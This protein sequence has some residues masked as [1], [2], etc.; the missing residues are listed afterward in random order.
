MSYGYDTNMEK[1]DIDFGYT[2]VRRNRS[3]KCIFNKGKGTMDW[4]GEMIQLLFPRNPDKIRVDPAIAM[5]FDHIPERLY[6]F[7]R[8]DAKYHSL[9]NFDYDQVWLL[10]PEKLNDPF[11]CVLT[12]SNES[13]LQYQMCSHLDNTIKKIEPDFRI[14]N[15]EREFLKK[16]DDILRDLVKIVVKQD[17][18][19]REENVDGFATA[20]RK[21][22]TEM[23]QPLVDGVKHSSLLSS[24]TER[25]DSI[26]MWSHYAQ[27]HTG[28]CL[29]YDLKSLGIDSM[30]TRMLYPILYRKDLLD[31]TDFIRR[32]LDNEKRF[33]N[34][35]GLY[36]AI[37]K[38]IEWS[39]EK[40][41]RLVFPFGVLE[42]EQAWRVPVPKAVYLGAKID[43]SNKKQI[44][45][46]AEKKNVPVYQASTDKTSFRL[47]FNRIDK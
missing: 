29:E 10:F 14:T 31:V 34:T 30:T 1:N 2:E 11:D 24:F 35:I 28:F 3:A 43:K 7:Y 47:I 42:Q 13:L 33:N 41:W 4:K 22:V 46:I 44:I 5:K 45:K 39:Y 15:N 12:Y 25:V 19:I 9:R 38:S 8:F 26:L 18:N 27:D 17:S 32:S 16:S 23:P 40:E 37:V 36:A 21:L 20:V 6:K